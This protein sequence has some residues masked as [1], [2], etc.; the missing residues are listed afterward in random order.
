VRVN[1]GS[2]APECLHRIDRISFQM[3]VHRKLAMV[4]VRFKAEDAV[5]SIQTSRR[6][7]ELVSV[8]VGSL[9]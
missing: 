3:T 5:K 1:C 2:H 9:I 7:P 6:S 4:M 8:R